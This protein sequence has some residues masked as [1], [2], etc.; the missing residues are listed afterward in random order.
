MC[1]EITDV[2]TTEALTSP[3]AFVAPYLVHESIRRTMIYGPSDR[4]TAQRLVGVCLYNNLHVLATNSRIHQTDHRLVEMLRPL[5]DKD[6]ESTRKLLELALCEG[7]IGRAVTPVLGIL[8][9]VPI[10]ERVRTGDG[11]DPELAQC[12]TGAEL[13]FAHGAKFLRLMDDSLSPEVA[14]VQ[15]AMAQSDVMRMFEA[16]VA[17]LRRVHR[18]NVEPDLFHAIM[19]GGACPAAVA[20]GAIEYL[21]RALWTD[22]VA[23]ELVLRYRD[24]TT[25]NVNGH[26]VTRLSSVALRRETA[27]EAE[28]DLMALTVNFRPNVVPVK[29]SKG[30]YGHELTLGVDPTATAAIGVGGGTTVYDLARTMGAVKA[31][32]SFTPGSCLSD[33]QRETSITVIKLPGVGGAKPCLF[34]PAMSPEEAE[35][36]SRVANAYRPPCE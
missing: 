21:G 1:E 14:Q 29:G 4:S 34:T 13:F 28:L 23:G 27:P 2:P 32:E 36:V 6:P 10:P 12:A 5:Q 17:Q 8:T 22:V 26:S 35:D 3:G 15:V 18:L 20:L 30:A 11:V 25:E 19:Q 16:I 31:S 7:V 24:K 33:D 9:G